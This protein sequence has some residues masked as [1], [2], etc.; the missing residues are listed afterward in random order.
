M[1]RTKRIS[2]RRRSWGFGCSIKICKCNEVLKTPG[3]YPLAYA[4]QEKRQWWLEHGQSVVAMSMARSHLK[5]ERT[6]DFGYGEI[7]VNR[8]PS[9]SQEVLYGR[10]WSL[11]GTSEHSCMLK[12]I[13]QWKVP[14]S[15]DLHFT[16]MYYL[17]Y[18]IGRSIRL[19][20]KPFV[21]SPHL[22]LTTPLRF[23]LLCISSHK[24]VFWTILSR[25]SRLQFLC[26]P[27]P[28]ISAALQVNLAVSLRLSLNARY[29]APLLLP[30]T[31]CEHYLRP[32]Q[33]IFINEFWFF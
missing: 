22:S 27:R 8:I 28:S 29:L 13:C 17:C 19:V 7:V 25:Q 4:K 9:T 3:L 21:L 32:T 20:Y 12:H 23:T 5:C 18:V 26:K 14:Q 1:L 6:N 24:G 15:C 2:Y 33:Y 10:S 30:L 31:M 16:W 11:A